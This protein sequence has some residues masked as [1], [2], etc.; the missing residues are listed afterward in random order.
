MTRARFLIESD[1]EKYLRNHSL[2]GVHGIELLMK[3]MDINQD[4]MVDQGD[5]V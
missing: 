3:R 5:F 4:G 1:V 2:E